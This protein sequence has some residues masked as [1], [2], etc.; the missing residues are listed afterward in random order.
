[1]SLSLE[2]FAAQPDR[3]QRAI[4][5]RD[6]RLLHGVR[7]TFAGQWAHDDDYWAEEIAAG[8]PTSSS[9][10]RAVLGGGPF[11]ERYG[12]LYGSAF[13][14]ICWFLFTDYELSDEY[15]SGFRSGWLVEVDKGLRQLGIT[16]PQLDDLVFSGM[17]DPL[18]HSEGIGYG[19]WD[20]ATCRAGLAEWQASSAQQRAELHPE[21]LGAVENCVEWMTEAVLLSDQTPEEFGVVAFL[22]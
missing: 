4:G 17:P 16:T 7:T 6:A 21:V 13:K 1:M 20:T 2:V 18:P 14:N 22:V 15:F 5:S 8:A 11:D 19:A 12:H 3:L 9:A 10:V